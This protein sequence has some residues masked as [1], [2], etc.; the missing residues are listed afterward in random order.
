MN[1][2]CKKFFSGSRLTGNDNIGAAVGSP[3][4][5][6]QAGSYVMIAADDAGALE[7]L[8]W[9]ANFPFLSILQGTLDAAGNLDQPIR[10]FEYNPRRRCLTPLRLL[11]NWR[12]R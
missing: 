7:G 5:G 11:L 4:Q 1:G 9:P 12:T 10:A 2:A 3:F 6:F 8:P